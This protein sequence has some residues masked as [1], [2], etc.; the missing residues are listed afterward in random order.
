MFFECRDLSF[1]YDG[2][3]V[4]RNLNFSVE[5]GDYF[6]IAGENGSGKSTLLKG[7]L[8]LLRPMGGIMRIDE[9]LAKATGYLPQQSAAQ[10]DFPASVAEVVLSGRIGRKGFMPF[11]L[12]HDKKIARD[13]M[14]RMGIAALK[15]RCFS[16]LSGG[17][18]RRALVARALGAAE[19]LLILDEPAAGLDPLA[20]QELYKLLEL[21]N[22]ELRITVI[23]VTHDID[24]A[25]RY[26]HKILHL[27]REQLFFGS[28]ED[29]RLSEVG[30]KFLTANVPKDVSKENGDKN[31]K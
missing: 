18:Q 19:K 15:D 17:Q 25:L 31:L 6:C 3:L 21:I 16:E 9:S 14:E 2:N 10:K 29:Y 22:R 23:M 13:N 27:C 24:Q 28:V 5:N 26:A 20:A 4:L 30:K 11:Y 12:P 1:G 8:G 7:L